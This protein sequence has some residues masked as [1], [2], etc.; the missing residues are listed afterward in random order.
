M[1]DS[2]FRHPGAL[3][4]TEHVGR[5]TRVWA[6]VHILPGARIGAECNICDHVFIE[7]EVG[8]RDLPHIT[9]S[10]LRELGLPLGPRKRIMAAIPALFEA[11]TPAPGDA[12]LL[13]PGRTGPR[14][15]AI[16][17]RPAAAV[18]QRPAPAIAPLAARQR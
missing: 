10:E 13:R 3:V 14:D 11:A 2:Y 18:S 7:N 6:F 8:L 15:P 1:S 12:W 17:L 16:C 5:D 4:E 9:D